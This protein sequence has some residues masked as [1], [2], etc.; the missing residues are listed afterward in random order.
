MPSKSW[1]WCLTH[2]PFRKYNEQSN[3]TVQMKT[4]RRC[5]LLQSS[6]FLGTTPQHRD[7]HISQT[8]HF[9]LEKPEFIYSDNHMLSSAGPLLSLW[10]RFDHVVYLH[11]Q[12]TCQ[13]V[14]H[15][16]GLF[17]V[18]E[19]HCHLFRLPHKNTNLHIWEN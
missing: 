1:K 11:S 16:C 19:V 5:L 3:Q 6:F 10:E 18:W 7:T 14:Q 4:V 17:P 12:N 2:I 8:V 13:E 9:F 15:I